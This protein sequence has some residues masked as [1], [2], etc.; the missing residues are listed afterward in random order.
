[1]DGQLEILSQVTVEETRRKG[2]AGHGMYLQSTV[3][4]ED[5]VCG[6]R[7]VPIPDVRLLGPQGSGTQSRSVSRSSVIDNR[8]ATLLVFL[9]P[10]SLFVKDDPHKT[11]VTL[12]NTGC[13]AELVQVPKSLRSWVSSLL[14]QSTEVVGEHSVRAKTTPRKDQECEALKE[15][16]ETT[17]VTQV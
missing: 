15:V 16:P 8:P 1:M 11:R 2:G 6:P 13:M 3:V 7:G 10:D 4:F 9:H 14:L 17:S 12:H 5:D